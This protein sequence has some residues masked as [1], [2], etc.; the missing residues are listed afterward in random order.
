MN[1]PGA[2]LRQQIFAGVALGFHRHSR[3]KAALDD[4]L[5]TAIDAPLDRAVLGGAEVKGNTGQDHRRAAQA[6]VDHHGMISSRTRRS[7][8]VVP[9]P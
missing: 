4:P 7:Y 9:V 3:G 1:V 8:R 6:E 2:V 5:Q